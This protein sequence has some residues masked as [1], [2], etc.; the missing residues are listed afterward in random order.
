MTHFHTKWRGIIALPIVIIVICS[1]L[2]L[3]SNSAMQ[4]VHAATKRANDPGPT[5]TSNPFQG[6]PNCT[7]YAWQQLHNTEGIDLQVNGNAGDW[8]NEIQNKQ[9]YAAWAVTSQSWVQVQLNTTPVVGDIVVVPYADGKYAF[10]SDGHVGYVEQLLGGGNFN[11]SAQDFGASYGTYTTMWNLQ[12]L[13]AHQNGAARFIHIVSGSSVSSSSTSS[14]SSMHTPVAVKN[15]DGHMEVFMVGSD[16]QLY[17]TWEDQNGNWQGWQSLGGN[18]PGQPAIGVNG[19]GSLEIFIVGDQGSNGATLFHAWQQTPGDSTSY[20]GWQPMAGNWPAGTPAVTQ[21][22]SGGLEVFMRGMDG[23]LYH[24]WQNNPGD[25]TNYTSWYPMGGSWTT[26]PVVAN[27][28]DGTM[29]VFM[30]GESTQ[31][32]YNQENESGNWSGWQSLGGSWSN[33]P[34]V[35]LNGSNELEVFIVGNQGAN[36]ASLFHAWQT[37]P[38]SSNWAMNQY[39][40]WYNLPGNWPAGTPTVSL[41]SGGTMDVF[42]PCL[43]NQPP[44]CH[45]YENADG[46]WSGPQQLGGYWPGDAS[47]TINLPGGIEV[48]MLG[49][50]GQIYHSWQN[51]A[52]DSSNYSGWYTL[53]TP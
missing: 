23:N 40:G 45:D 20:T 22:L 31:L 34:S 43:G 37:S 41:N 36:G 24:A 15:I 8:A 52:G 1:T 47:S 53:G 39:G 46:S 7:W 29:E 25:S 35:I 44:L 12:D 49:Y 50:S 11:V 48:F 30:V 38:E 9:P 17:H 28:S 14:S 3:I 33:Q 27:N 2:L 6:P 18:W 26:D 21:N 10:T 51:N 32:Y 42:L 5:I 19:D 16:G 4:V 13:Q